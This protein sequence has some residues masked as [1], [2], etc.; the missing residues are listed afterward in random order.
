MNELSAENPYTDTGDL[1][2]RSLISIVNNTNHSFGITLITSGMTISGSIISAH[3]YFSYYSDALLKIS[4][5]NERNKHFQSLINRFK[6]FYTK[7]KE[8]DVKSSTDFIHLKDAFFFNAN[9]KPV[10][11]RKGVWW[12]GRLIEISGFS[13][14]RLKNKRVNG[15][16]ISG[17][18]LFKKNIVFH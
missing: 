13:I 1:F 17:D 15:N 8:T 9:G 5:K 14:G 6:H 3:Y 16:Y 11:N 2:L 7:G 12:R 4:D 18:H 10:S